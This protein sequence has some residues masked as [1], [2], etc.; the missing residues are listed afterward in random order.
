MYRVI[1]RSGVLVGLIVVA[2][3]LA[4]GVASAVA[5]EGPRLA[6]VRF[7]ERP[8]KLE[9]MTSDSSGLRRQTI[10]GGPRR[11][12]PLPVLLDAP[13]WSPDGSQIAFAGWPR[14]VSLEGDLPTRIYVVGADGSGLRAVPGTGG[15]YGPVFSP[16][17]HTLAFS[18]NR[19]R[20]R[21]TRGGA[22]RPVFRS[23][24]TWLVDLNG[25]GERRLT[26]WR[27]RLAISPSS[28]SPDGAVLALSRSGGQR[29]PELLAMRLDGSGSVVLARDASDGVYSP[30]GSEI[31]FLRLRERRQGG[32]APETRTETTTDLYAMRADGSEPRPLT[33]TPGKIELWP[34]WDPSG[35]RLAF[36]QLRGGLLGL[37][38][39]GDSLAQINA[40]G[41][42]RRTVFASRQLAFYGPAWQPGSGRDAGPIAC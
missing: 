5:P 13:A 32:G 39:F 26:E 40:D 18:R 25:G 11:V 14:R 34:S 24:T 4:A 19:E 35:Q 33:R 7:S 42:C 6:F 9:L 3:M 15:G 17:G 2:S 23:T 29:F 38:G 36:V 37:L 41:S 22:E 16:D 27:N 20:T 8:V 12:R 21:E 10:A 28:F 31:A 30:D 1:R